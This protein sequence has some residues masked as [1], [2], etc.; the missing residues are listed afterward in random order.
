LYPEFKIRKNMT[1]LNEDFD[2]LVAQINVKLKE[3]AAAVEEAVKLSEK[4]GLNGSLILT[5]WTCEDLE[6]DEEEDLEEKFEKIDVSDLESA[7]G[8]AGW[9]TSSSYC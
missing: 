3:A 5:Q 6:E 4:A 7:L 9:S 1:E 2:Q 8:N